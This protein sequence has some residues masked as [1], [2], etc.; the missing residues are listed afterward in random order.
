MFNGNVM[1]EVFYDDVM[2]NNLDTEEK[3]FSCRRK[4]VFVPIKNN[5]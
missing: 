3:K 5:L 2:K 1:L 4:K